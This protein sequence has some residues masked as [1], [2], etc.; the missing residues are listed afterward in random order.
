MD[1]ILPFPKIIHLEVYIIYIYKKYQI[2]VCV[3]KVELHRVRKG[4]RKSKK[5]GKRVFLWV[6]SPNGHNIQD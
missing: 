5:C 3:C 6:H 4:E 1:A 2:Y